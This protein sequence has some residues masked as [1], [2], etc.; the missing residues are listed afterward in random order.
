MANHRRHHHDF[1][2]YL[3]SILSLVPEAW[4][5]L[6]ILGLKVSQL[7]VLGVDLKIYCLKDEFN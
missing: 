5:V 6:I 4:L 7:D 2:R 1:S 3:H